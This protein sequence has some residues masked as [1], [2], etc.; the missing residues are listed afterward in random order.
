MRFLLLLVVLLVGACAHDAAPLASAPGAAYQ[1]G[2]G[3]KLRIQT[4][5]ED[6]LS[7]EFTIDGEGRIAFPLLGQV[8]AAKQTADELQSALTASLARQ[9]L[10]SPQVTVEVMNYRPVYIL[11]EVT[12][13]GEFPFSSDLSVF[14]LV[15]KAGGFTYRANQHRVFIRHAGE[16]VEVA[17]KLDAATPVRPGD[18]VRVGDRVF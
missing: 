16:N 10:R 13:P 3:D 6:R 1:L 4:F 17:Y 12:R 15:A 18:T 5:G 9:A 7:G 8:P 11:G 2:P 14:A